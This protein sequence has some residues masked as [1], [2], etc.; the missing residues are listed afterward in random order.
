MATKKYY[1]ERSSAA[2]ILGA[3]LIAGL[4]ATLTAGIC[5]DW[6]KRNPFEQTE[7]EP[8]SGIDTSIKE[9]GVSLKLLATT[10]TPEGYVV[11]TFTFAVQPSNA[12]D[13]TVTVNAK[14]K[15]GTDCVSVL[16]TAV[17]NEAK[18]IS[19]I[20]REAFEKQIIITVTANANAEA[21]ATITVDYV[22]KLL[23][24]KSSVAK[25]ESTGNYYYFGGNYAG[26]NI[27]DFS[28]ASMIT[29]T[30]SVYTK[31]KTYTFAMKEVN[32]RE[33]E[34]LCSSTEYSDFISNSDHIWRALADVIQKKIQSG[35]ALPTADEIWNIDSEPG[36]HSYLAYMSKNHLNA[37]TDEYVSFVFEATYYCVEDPSIE[38]KFNEGRDGTYLFLSLDYDFSGK[39]VEVSGV[40][41]ETPNIEF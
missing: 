19:V 6:F 5:T 29:P 3:L 39:T 37:S 26:N 21:K 36:W 7:K 4:S 30:Y 22:K 12:S 17:D 10:T 11:K 13:Q 20:N 41:V 18:T 9:E 32:V 2:L 34:W 23:E 35:E 1:K 33:D 38:V 16:R 40:T 15:D 27:S 24:I 31:D 14:Y 8:S 25:E 28:I